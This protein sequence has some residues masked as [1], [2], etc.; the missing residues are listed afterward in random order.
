LVVVVVDR[1]PEEGLR[2][3]GSSLR[4]ME[5]DRCP[6]PPTLDLRCTHL[7]LDGLLPLAGDRRT[8]YGVRRASP[9]ALR[10]EEKD[11]ERRLAS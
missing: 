1:R 3:L 11:D 4:V 2:E 9:L 5:E 8:P 7:R 10:H 6:P